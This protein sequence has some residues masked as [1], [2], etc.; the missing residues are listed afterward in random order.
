MSCLFT[1]GGPSIGASTSTSV[2]PMTIQGQ[3]PLGLTCLISLLSK[4]LSRVFF[5]T[6]FQKHQFFG[7]QPSYGPILTSIHTYWKNHNSDYTDLCWQ[8]DVLSL[9][10]NM[11]SRFV[12][13]FIPRSKRLL[14]S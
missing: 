10:F 1:L 5:N 4:G 11:L 6:T 2:L 8:S 9:L 3:F 13:A 12:I 7:A 14:I